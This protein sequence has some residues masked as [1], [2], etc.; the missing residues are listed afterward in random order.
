[1]IAQRYKFPAQMIGGGRKENISVAIFGIARHIGVP[2]SFP[3]YGSTP[4]DNGT[5]AQLQFHP[6]SNFHPWKHPVR[7]ARGGQAR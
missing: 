1:M 4:S 7:W 2:S 6:F 5:D 3:T